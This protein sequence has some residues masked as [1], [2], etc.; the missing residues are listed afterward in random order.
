[1]HKWLEQQ[2]VTVNGEQVKLEE[3]PVLTEERKIEEIV[4]LT[5]AHLP[6]LRYLLFS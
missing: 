1:M 4:R 3:Y 2:T 5:P 6:T